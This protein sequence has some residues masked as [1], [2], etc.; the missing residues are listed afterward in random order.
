[1][2]HIKGVWR[3]L[4]AHQR[5]FNHLE[6]GDYESSLSV[7]RSPSLSATAIPTTRPPAADHMA[8]LPDQ[9]LTS[10]P[11]CK[12]HQLF[13]PPVM[14]PTFYQKPVAALSPTRCNWH[15]DSTAPCW[16]ALTGP[17]MEVFCCFCTRNYFFGM[18]GGSVNW[19]NTRLVDRFNAS[20]IG[21]GSLCTSRCNS[22]ASHRSGCAK[23]KRIR[24]INFN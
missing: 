8:R 14:P 20:S 19:F 4:Q 9:V 5:F 24:V 1:M 18:G 23:R 10:S 3:R 15:T 7:H 16:E 6:S 22:S 11:Q 12:L 2:L 13:Q 17:E 21:A